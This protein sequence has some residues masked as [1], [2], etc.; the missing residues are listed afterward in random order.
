MSNCTLKQ[1]KRGFKPWAHYYKEELQL[2]MLLV[3]IIIAI[4]VIEI[5]ATSLAEG[6]LFAWW[7]LVAISCTGIYLAIKTVFE[8]IC[9][10]GAT[11]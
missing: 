8:R 6:N 5:L 7:L 1:I 10:F 11:R 2:T 4:T 3:G 9:E